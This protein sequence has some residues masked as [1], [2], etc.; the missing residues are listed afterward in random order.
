MRMKATTEFNKNLKLKKN[1]SQC[2]DPPPPRNNNKWSVPHI[3]LHT[4]QGNE[5]TTIPV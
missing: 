3:D 2:C 1:N 4:T 5:Y